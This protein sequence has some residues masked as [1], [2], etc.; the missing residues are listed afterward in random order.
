MRDEADEEAGET[1]AAF[2]WLYAAALW[3]ILFWVGIFK[4]VL[5]LMGVDG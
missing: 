3:V 5:F 1:I 4:L 2:G